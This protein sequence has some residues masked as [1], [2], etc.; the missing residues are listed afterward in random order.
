MNDTPTGARGLP[1]P[2]DAALVPR[3]AGI[4]TFMRLP[5]VTAP[6]DVDVA[7]VGD[8]GHSPLSP[9][10]SSFADQPDEVVDAVHAAVAAPLAQH[11]EVA[12]AMFRQVLDLHAFVK[13]RIESR[14]ASAR[15]A[16][17]RCILKSDIR[18]SRCCNASR[19]SSRR[20]RWTDRCMACRCR[21]N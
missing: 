10:A 4:P 8:H 11:E 17:A 7:L 6:S 12:R 9:F 18:R 20:R 5:T 2:I 1:Q 16:N 3:F 14:R 19:T 21:R 13:R 15:R